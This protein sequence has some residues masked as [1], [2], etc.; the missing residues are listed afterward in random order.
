MDFG[1][2]STQI[3][4][5]TRDTIEDPRNE[6]MLKLYGQ[7]YKVYTHSFLC[8]GR[9]QVLKRLLSKLLQ[10]PAWAQWGCWLSSPCSCPLTLVFIQGCPPAPRGQL[11]TFPSQLLGFAP[12]P[13]P[14]SQGF[15]PPSP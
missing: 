8:Y 2:A 10:V 12:D 15:L 14:W 9:D 7:A 4:F 1:G 13:L 3:T 5:E 11:H 6:V